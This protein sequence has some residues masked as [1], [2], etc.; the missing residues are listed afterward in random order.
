MKGQ[1]YEIQ[2]YIQNVENPV[3][4]HELSSQNQNFLSPNLLSHS[5]RAS[6][7]DAIDL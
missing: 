4:L 6:A 1:M 7:A 3:D 2:A 5:A